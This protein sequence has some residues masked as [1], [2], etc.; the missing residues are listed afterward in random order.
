[1]VGRHLRFA[2]Q[3]TE[4]LQIQIMRMKGKGRHNIIGIGIAPGMRCRSI[5]DRQYLDHFHPRQYSPVDQP[6]EIA[7]VADAIRTVAPKGEYRHHDTGGTPGLFLDAKVLAI[8]HQ[9]C[10]IRNSGDIRW[11]QPV[12][13]AVVTLLPC[14]E[15]VRG[16]I[17]DHIF[18]FQW[19]KDGIDIDRQHPIV[20]SQVF[21]PQ[22]A[23]S[24]PVAQRRMTA[25]DGQ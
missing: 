9:D 6:P 3:T 13:G 24:I 1:M 12:G 4:S 16:I 8:G 23:G 22:I 2:L 5:I 11:Q 21:H 17:D 7:E 20:L 15:G 18:I 25:D 14:H 19:Q 10:P